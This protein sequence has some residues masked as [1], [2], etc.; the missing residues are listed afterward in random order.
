MLKSQF[1]GASFLEKFRVDLQPAMFEKMIADHGYKVTWEKNIPCP[2]RLEDI[3]EHDVNCTVCNGLG[4]LYYDTQ[5][6]E[7]AMVS[8]SLREIF[9]QAGKFLPGMVMVTSHAKDK[10][11]RWDRLTLQES[12]LRY[13]EPIRRSD[14]GS[15]DRTKYEIVSVLTIRDSLRTYTEDVDF[16]VETHGITWIP[17]NVP[18]K[19]YSISYMY[20]PVYVVLDLLHAIRD[21]HVLTE[22]TDQNRQLPIQAVAQLEFLIGDESAQ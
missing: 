1:T 10:I 11:A 8:I 9:M 3:H 15:F 4:F 14:K 7:M 16:E 17:G 12:Q 21:Q 20:R 5:N 18:T 19:F 2:N 22:G 6:T 13:S